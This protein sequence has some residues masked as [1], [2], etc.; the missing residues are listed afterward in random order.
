MKNL[1]V[2]ALFTLAFRAQAADQVVTVTFE[3][4]AATPTRSGEKLDPS[5]FSFGPAVTGGEDDQSKAMS[6]G[7]GKPKE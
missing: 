7:F 1:I 5:L 6:S 4:I 3:S 2:V